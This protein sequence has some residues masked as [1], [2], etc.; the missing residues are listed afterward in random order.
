MKKHYLNEYGDRIHK[1]KAYNA[2]TYWAS[3]YGINNSSS[4]H[5]KD[6]FSPHNLRHCFTTYLTEA[7]MYEPFI[8]WLRG[9]SP[10]KSIDRY[11]HITIEK[12]RDT[13]DKSM[14]IFGL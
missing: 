7:T 11:K 1:N 8:E 6:H 9:D 5:L 13:Y 3:R 4:T 12:V 14:P 2:V 10:S